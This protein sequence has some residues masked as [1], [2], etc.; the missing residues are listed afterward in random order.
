MK[1]MIFE[2]LKTEGPMGAGKL[3]ELIGEDCEAVKL[4][5][6]DMTDA[7]LLVKNGAH[8]WQIANVDKSKSVM[9][10]QCN[11]DTRNKNAEIIDHPG[12]NNGFGKPKQDEHQKTARKTVADVLADMEL[13]LSSSPATIKNASDKIDALR[14]LAEMS[15]QPLRELLCEIAKDIELVV[16]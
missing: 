9:L 5:L 12:I 13:R 1:N 7:G 3:A 6:A 14:K 16:K 11:R 2:T 10:Q 15:E 8:R 4:V